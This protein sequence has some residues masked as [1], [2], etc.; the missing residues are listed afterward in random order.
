[1]EPRSKLARACA[2]LLI[3]LACASLRKLRIG[4]S[5]Q[6]CASLR[7]LAYDFYLQACASL[8]QACASLQIP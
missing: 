3:I 8:P 1:L 4:T 7:K 6:A 5:Q 2:S